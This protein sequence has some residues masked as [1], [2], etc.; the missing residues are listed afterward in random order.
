[1]LPADF[2]WIPRGQYAGD[3]LALTV[4]GRWV[5]QLMTRANGKDWY[6][7]LKIGPGLMDDQFR[8]CESRESGI[9]GVEAWA[10]RNQDALRAGRHLYSRADAE[11]EE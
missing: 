8:D 2:Q 11:G 7:L 5:A 10:T 4:G 9:A 3:E 6:A 1:M